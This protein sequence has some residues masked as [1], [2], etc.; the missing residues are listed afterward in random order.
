[1][2]WFG[3]IVAALV[4]AACGSSGSGQESASQA[5]VRHLTFVSKGQYGPEWDELHPAQQ[6]V[7]PRDKYMQCA[8]EHVFPITDIKATEEYDDT[9]TV[10]EAGSVVSRAVTVSYKLKDQTQSQT[11]HEV[12]VDG[13]WRWVLDQKSIDAYK[14]GTCP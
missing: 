4:L 2:R 8:S 14:A 3:I 1:M 11:F 12:K 5:L 7:V 10:P 13:K 9:I 6:A